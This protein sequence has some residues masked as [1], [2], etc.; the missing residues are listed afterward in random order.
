MKAGRQILLLLSVLVFSCCEKEYHCYC[1]DPR[2]CDAFPIKGSKAEARWKCSEIQ[3]PF[4]ES[5]CYLM[6]DEN[7]LLNK[8]SRNK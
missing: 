2:S 5:E 8:I 1:P 6:E 4:N 7:S 3:N